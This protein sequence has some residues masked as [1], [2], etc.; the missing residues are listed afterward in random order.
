MSPGSKTRSTR[1]SGR[2]TRPGAW[3]TRARPGIPRSSRPPT[4]AISD[5]AASPTRKRTSRRGRID[6]KERGGQGGSGQ[7]RGVEEEGRRG[8]VRAVGVAQG[9]HPSG[10][11]VVALDGRAHETPQITHPFHQICLVEHPDVQ[12]AKEA[13]HA[14]LENRPPWRKEIGPGSDLLPERDEIV[15]VAAGAGKEKKRVAGATRLEAMDEFQILRAGT[16]GRRMRLH[17]LPTMGAGRGRVS[18]G[19]TAS[20]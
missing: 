12:T 18:L 5:Y 19:R 11:E 8:G 16:L 14:V 15:L 4:G 9:V 13:G 3:R 2:R 6:R 10:V 7:G 17:A 20:I 1:R